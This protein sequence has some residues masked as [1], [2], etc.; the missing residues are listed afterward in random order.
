MLIK[1]TLEHNR[2]IGIIFHTVIPHVISTC[3]RSY[4]PLYRMKTLGTHILDHPPGLPTR[5]LEWDSLIVNQPVQ[6][7]SPSL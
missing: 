3:S 6:H 4:A 5:G 2:F 1:E 7:A